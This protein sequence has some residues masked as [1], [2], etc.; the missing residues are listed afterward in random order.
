[1][2]TNNFMHVHYT[3][4]LAEK[5]EKLWQ[6][7]SKEKEVKVTERSDVKEQ[8]F[9]ENWINNDKKSTVFERKSGNVRLVNLL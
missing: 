4:L 2:E 1:M 6:I 3:C 5:L 7:K 8:W 9:L